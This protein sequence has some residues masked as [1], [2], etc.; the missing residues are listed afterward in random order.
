VAPA[1]AA[2]KERF[3][4]F[5]GTWGRQYPAITRLWE[6]SWAEFVPFLAFDVEVTGR[7]QSHLQGRSGGLGLVEVADH[8]RGAPPVQ[9]GGGGQPDAPGTPGHRDCQ[10]VDAFVA[11]HGTPG[12]LRC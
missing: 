12:C 5:S 9:Q 4:E 10:P 1:G 7:S 8:H 6:S 3:V 2:A 11:C